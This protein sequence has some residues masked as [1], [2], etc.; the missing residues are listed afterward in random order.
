MIT[1]GLLVWFG[2][3]TDAEVFYWIGMVIVAVAFV[4]EHRV[5][6]PSTTCPG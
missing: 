2:L 5:V 1:T 4:Y 3:A 6:R